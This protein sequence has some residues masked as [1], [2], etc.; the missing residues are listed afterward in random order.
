[1]S[2][3]FGVPELNVQE[4]EHKRQN[5]GDFIWLDVREPHEM[6]IAYI[7][8]KR[9]VE[10]PMSQLAAQQLDAVPEEMADKGAEVVV[11][12]HKGVRSAQVSAWLRQQG[13]TNVYNMAGGI[14]AWAREIDESVGMY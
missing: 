5:N 1:M 3:P 14:D 10:L 9:I 13:W 2:N 8:D 7:D 12:C 11:F 4:V 6:Q